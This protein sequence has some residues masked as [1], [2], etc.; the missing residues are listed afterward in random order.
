MLRVLR[1]AG[2]LEG[3]TLGLAQHLGGSDRFLSSISLATVNALVDH[4]VKGKGD[5]P[6]NM[7][8]PQEGAG[9]AWWNTS[10]P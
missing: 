6:L 10:I 1:E 3:N 2:D 7:L 4:G 8:G 5:D 9:C